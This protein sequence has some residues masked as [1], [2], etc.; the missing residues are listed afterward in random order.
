MLLPIILSFPAAF[1]VPL[2]TTVNDEEA[3]SIT[4]ILSASNSTP[5]PISARLDTDKSAGS[6]FSNS[7]VTEYLSFTTQY[8][9]NGDEARDQSMNFM[10]KRLLAY[11]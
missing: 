7:I 3:A 11:Q 10:V 8:T 4:S 9:S 2:S 1:G 6:G 5:S